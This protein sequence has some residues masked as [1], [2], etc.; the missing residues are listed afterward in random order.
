MKIVLTGGGTGGHVT[1]NLALIPCLKQKGF[2]ISYI[3]EYEGPE[4]TLIEPLK[5]VPYYGISAGKLRRYLD[6][7]NLTDPF[8]VI[9]GYFQSLRLL[10]RISPDIVFSKGGFVSVPVVYAAK[11]LHIP[12]VAHE[13]DLTPGLANNLRVP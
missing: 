7:K 4:R 9:R 1:P 13:S 12:V 8:R 11:T 5:D 3:G 6:L 10:R 2:D